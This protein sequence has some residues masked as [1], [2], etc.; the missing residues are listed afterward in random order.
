M[1]V[2]SSQF[3]GNPRQI[4]EVQNLVRDFFQDQN[5]HHATA[6]DES[7]LRVFLKSDKTCSPRPTSA[8]DYYLDDHH[9]KMVL[10]P[11]VKDLVT[12]TSA[13]N[14]EELGQA[15][16][17]A[18]L[19]SMSITDIQALNNRNALKYSRNQSEVDSAL[20]RD[21]N[22]CVITDTANPEACH[23]FPFASLKQQSQRTLGPDLELMTSLW[24]NDRVDTLAEK[25]TMIGTHDTTAVDTMRNM[26]CLSP[27]LHDWW[28]RGYFAL[29]PIKSSSES[30]SGGT[31]TRLDRTAKKPR[32]EQEW[33][34]HI[35]FHWL[36]KTDIP[37]LTSQVNFSQD[38]VAKLQDLKGE[39]GGLV[40]TFNAT[41]GRLV[42][43]GQM[44]TITADSSDEIPDFDIL[45]LQWDL[46]RMWRLAG[47]ADPAIYP[48]GG[49]Y[50][51]DDTK[52]PVG[53]DPQAT[54][55]SV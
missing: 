34:I 8:S 44:F 33:S 43:S 40:K 38:P 49:Y 14:F 51:D 1:S 25:L 37:T 50:D 35:R 5:A 6:L 26:I 15:A 11:Q 29:E 28:T 17:W 4:T 54:D 41:T 27:Q 10:I 47:D 48:L 18:A 19:W 12:A 39:G 52:V 53:E 31:P 21:N 3:T 32:L 9:T 30:I 23:I 45:L 42:E 7:S 22:K 13:A 20:K 16:F 24:G 55:N 2:S 46:L 36:R